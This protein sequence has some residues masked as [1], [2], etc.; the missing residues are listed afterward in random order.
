MPKYY[1][2]GKY[3]AMLSYQKESNQPKFHMD[4]TIFKNK[5]IHLFRLNIRSLF[6]KNKFDMFKYQMINSGTDII[7]SSET[8]LKDA[9]TTN[10]LDIPGYKL[11]RLD[12]SWKE[13]D[14]IKKGGGLCIYIKQNISF[15]DS[16]VCQFNISSKDIEIQWMILKFPKMRDMYRADVYRPPQGN[17]KKMLMKLIV[18]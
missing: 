15:N 1:W 12:R 16:H 3:V 10:I 11:A 13:N 8:W 18:L 5:G 4:N 17:V 9:L 7:C 2:L 14:D 6:S